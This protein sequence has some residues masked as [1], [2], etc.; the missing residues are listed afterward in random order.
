M[1]SIVVHIAPPQSGAICTT[2]AHRTTLWLLRLCG[3]I[4]HR[5][6]H[7]ITTK[8]CNVLYYGT[9]YHFVAAETV[10]CNV[11]YH[12]TLYHFVAAE[13]MCSVP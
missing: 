13:T 9:M 10:W 7:C 4:C 3:V 12:G 2:L 6:A 5:S 11:H 8:W 1:L